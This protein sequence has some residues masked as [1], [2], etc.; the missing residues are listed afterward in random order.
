[1]T[2][3]EL[4]TATLHHAIVRHMVDHGCAPSRQ[5]LADYFGAPML[6]LGD[7]I[8][9]DYSSYPNVSRWLKTMTSR[10]SWGTVNE[11]FYKYLV[12]PFQDRPYVRL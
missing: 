7:V 2:A 1:M 8:R 6:T 4:N 10:P 12:A 5:A 9:L 3:V 11:P